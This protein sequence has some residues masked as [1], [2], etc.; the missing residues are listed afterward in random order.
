M[1]YACYAFLYRPTI[2]FHSTS[3]EY[4]LTEVF[5]TPKPLYFL[6]TS[7][8]KPAFL[9]AEM[10]R[11]VQIYS[12]QEPHYLMGIENFVLSRKV[13]FIQNRFV[14]VII[15]ALYYYYYFNFIHLTIREPDTLQKASSCNWKSKPQF[16]KYLHK[17]NTPNVCKPPCKA[18]EFLNCVLCGGFVHHVRTAL[19]LLQRLIKNGDDTGAKMNKC[20]ITIQA[21][22]LQP[23]EISWS[24]LFSCTHTHTLNQKKQ[25]PSINMICSYMYCWLQSHNYMIGQNN[26]RWVLAQ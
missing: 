25:N 5:N 15:S 8:Y 17:L 9:F 19:T 13:Y 14:H 23:P 22:K 7:H 6:M 4:Q 21:I 18:W 16:D 10:S 20:W 12:C 1:W 2:L 26:K 11:N 24:K 3:D